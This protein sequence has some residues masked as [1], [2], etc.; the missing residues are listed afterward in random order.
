M[1]GGWV[2][3]MFDISAIFKPSYHECYLQ[4]AAGD[5]LH[6]DRIHQNGTFST[7]GVAY[8]LAKELP[9]YVEAAFALGQAAVPAGRKLEVWDSAPSVQERV[10]RNSVRRQLRRGGG[11]LMTSG[12]FTMMS[13][14][15]F[16]N[17]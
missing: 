4:T 17:T 2:E 7:G 16:G 13:S 5:M 3:S 1:V 15:E 11:A 14:A 8:P 6:I 10:A 12:S 9:A